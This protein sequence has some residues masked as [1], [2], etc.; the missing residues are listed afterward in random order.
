MIHDLKKI[1][2]LID[3]NLERVSKLQMK[4]GVD[5]EH[6]PLNKIFQDLLNRE[7][8]LIQE[9]LGEQDENS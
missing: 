3:L 6:H 2:E 1:Q 8:D 5:F 7:N 4:L 9:K